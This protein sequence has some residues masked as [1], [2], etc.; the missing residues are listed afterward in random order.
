M[1]INFLEVECIMDFIIELITNQTFL[2]VVSGTIV[3]VLSQL[4]L[5]LIINPRKEYKKLKQKVLYT[6]SL[7]C[8]YYANPYNKLKEDSNMRPEEEYKIA[9]TE[10]RKIGAE[11]AS[12]IGIVPKYRLK[13]RKKLLEVQQS[14]IGLSNGMYIYRDYNPR[15]DNIDCDFL[16]FYK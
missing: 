9:S 8:C 6:I 3:Y 7:Y 14:L 15:K 16:S 4:F 12:Y 10:L 11:F 1:I 13:K 5:E 2:T